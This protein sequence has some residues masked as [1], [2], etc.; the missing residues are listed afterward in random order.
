M[1]RDNSTYCTESLPNGIVRATNAVTPPEVDPFEWQAVLD[2]KQ[3][4]LNLLNDALM[5]GGDPSKIAEYVAEEY[6]QHNKE[7]P[8]G[9]APFEALAS[10]PNRPLNYTDI[11]LCVA[12]GNFVS[13]LC[14]AT[15]TDE[16]GTKDYAQVDIFR[17]E[18]GK[19]VEHWDN[20]EP[21]P[22]HSV[23]SGKF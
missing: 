4:V 20:V 5:P 3:L 7:V 13:T 6:I 15:W 18:N 16:N 11:V 2:N 21:V 14:K 8:D 1:W 10:A 12:Q 17:V 22:E 19:V 9:R 23:N